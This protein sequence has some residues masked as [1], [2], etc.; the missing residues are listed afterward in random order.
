MSAAVTSAVAASAAAAAA[1][2][3][4]RIQRERQEQS[5]QCHFNHSS[6]YECEQYC[7]GQEEIFYKE[8]SFWS[9]TRTYTVF[10]E[11]SGDDLGTKTVN[12]ITAKGLAVIFGV[13]IV[14][15][16]VFIGISNLINKLK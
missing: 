14:A 6:S 7:V 9:C 16:L 1:A 8:N 15:I 12:D 2:N 13:V 4:A 11:C 10:N 5:D 3:N